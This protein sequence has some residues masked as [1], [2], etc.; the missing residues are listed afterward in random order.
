MLD[1][2]RGVRP[3][4][5]YIWGYPANE[6]WYVLGQW[7]SLHTWQVVSAV[8]QMFVRIRFSQSFRNALRG[9]VFLFAMVF[10]AGGCG[11]GGSS[12]PAPSP[13]PIPDPGTLSLAAT[14]GDSEVLLQWADVAGV[15]GYTLY[16]AT[17]GGIQPA[18][19]GIWISQHD[20]VM[21]ENVT[22]PKIV[23]GLNNGTEYFFVVTVTAGGL[24]SGPSNEV[25]AIPRHTPVVNGAGK[26]NDTGIDWCANEATNRLPCPVFGYPGQDGDFGRDAAARAG[27]LE[28]VGD[29]AAGFDFTKIAN[30]GSALPAS[31]TL[32]S[33]AND[34]A[35]TRDNVTGLIW[36]VKVDISAHLRY[37]GHTY[38]WYDPA[39]PDGNPGTQG[40]G[41]CIGS[42]CDI[43]GFVQVVNVQG[44][45]G[46]SD[47]RA[48][49]RRELQG[50]VDYGS[51]P[52][53]DLDFFPNTPDT[54]FWSGSPS[55]SSSNFAWVVNFLGGG[56][57]TVFGERSDR[58]RIRLVRGGP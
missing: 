54:F 10:A 51:R 32:G 5:F 52:A 21:V 50:I 24:E 36:E 19:F 37:Q 27:S 55:A 39:S 56:A 48:P 7:V 29:G 58:H 34:W 23:D 20:G 3:A 14:A 15:D 46:A 11:G 18:N 1:I 17:E 42:A 31:A 6:K 4:E 47:W 43:T 53:I 22:S 16:H 44:L 13:V 26:L 35:C 57:T 49:T 40:G 8:A 9:S 33:G 38:T 45:C 2:F 41:I 30:D 25:R 28:K 12:D